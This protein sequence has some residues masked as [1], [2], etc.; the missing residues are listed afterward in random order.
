MVYLIHF[1]RPYKGARHYM[2]ATADLDQRMIDHR[3]GRG[4]SL[5]WAL[6]KAG[7]RYRVVRRWRGLWLK[8][9]QL[10]SRFTSAQLCPHC[11]GPSAYRRGGR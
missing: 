7:I 3:A 8:E 9:Q 11:C 4:A 10:K 1:S 2:G 5:L 6:N